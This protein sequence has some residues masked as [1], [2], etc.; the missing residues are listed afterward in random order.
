MKKP[1]TFARYGSLP[2]A[3]RTT[4][5]IQALIGDAKAAGQPLPTD[6]DIA[7]HLAISP[8]RVARHRRILGL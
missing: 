5:T 2:Q 8:L 7:G 3:N 4:Q 6:Q 1:R